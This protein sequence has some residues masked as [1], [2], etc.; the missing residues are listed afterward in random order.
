MRP[1][2]APRRRQPQRRSERPGG[3]R[4]FLRRAAA[5]PDLYHRLLTVGWGGFFAGI[6]IAY[7]AFNLVFAGLYLLE[8]GSIANAAP[9]AFADAF[10]FS[11]QTMA[12]IGYG[13]MHPATLYANLLVTAEVLLG[14]MGFALATG[15]IFARFSRPTARVLFSRVAVVGRYDGRPM[16]M[17]RVANQRSNRILEAQVNL[18][19][20][21][22]EVTAEDLAMRRLHDL[23][24]QRAR[25]PLFSLTWTVMH[26]IDGKS[27]LHGAT[28]ASLAAAGAELIVTIIGIDET[29]SQTIHARHVYRDTEILWDRRF[30]D[31]LERGAD[32]N[33]AVDYRRFHDTVESTG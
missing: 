5:L 12:T 3:L 15:L 10:F 23:E 21:R 28:R 16:L 8:R 27:P 25:S 20:A 9:G 26:A 19:L 18:T 24:P 32:R 13:D 33:L 7:A 4:H 29:L 22:N 17:F 14:L 1:R 6:A 11:V 30:V 2:R 31:I